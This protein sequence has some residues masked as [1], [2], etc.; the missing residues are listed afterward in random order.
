MAFPPPTSLE[1]K[2]L[3]VFYTKNDSAQLTLARSRILIPVYPFVS[4]ADDS[5]V[6]SGSSSG[7]NPQARY[8][9]VA[10]R[11][12]ID[13]LLLSCPDLLHD[14]HRDYTVYH[15]DPLESISEDPS[16]QSLAK[17]GISVGLGLIS[18]LKKDEKTVAITGTVM[19][20]KTGGEG[21]EVVFQLRE[22]AQVP[23]QGPSN[24]VDYTDPNIAAAIDRYRAEQEAKLNSRRRRP[25]APQGPFNKRL[26]PITAH[27]EAERLLA[28]AGAGNYG[29]RTK[30]ETPATHAPSPDAYLTPAT[31]TASTPSSSQQPP[32]SQSTVASPPAS[33]TAGSNASQPDS[34]TI[35]AILSLI[36]S[37]P[38]AASKV[39]NNPLL[40]L[41]LQSLLQQHS[42]NTPPAAQTSSVVDTSQDDEVIV[43]DKENV[44][45]SAFR[46]RA[47]LEGAKLAEMSCPVPST[48][49]STG[50]ETT[51]NASHGLGLGAR[52][53]SVSSDVSQVRSQQNTAEEQSSSRNRSS[54]GSSRKGKEKAHQPNSNHSPRGY[55]LP[56][57][58]KPGG[59]TEPW[60]SPPRS[61]HSTFNENTQAGSSRAAPI[62]IPDSPL[63][64]TVPA[65][66]PIRGKNHASRKPYVL[67]EW[68]RTTT[69]TQPRFSE[70]ALKAMADAEKQREEDRKAKRA[71]WA[72]RSKSTSALSSGPSSSSGSQVDAS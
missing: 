10:L 70:E 52:S 50:T 6:A 60:S 61:R 17:N 55:R 27:C 21:V 40:Q 2:L 13:T 22:R 24:G 39:E 68:A 67:P 51:H 37:S 41:A 25:K 12:C 46:R 72:S 69:A 43:L 35:L 5:A 42:N 8:A 57:Y 4:F 49:T 30:S 59:S 28:E 63:A 32:S 71:K 47:E 65:S 20:M 36:D 16:A 18:E 19:K 66:S 7:S 29:R 31:S 1:N 11:A 15:F 26:Q 53:N 9:T 34:A 56:I 58:A 62:V 44:N 33:Q 3:R 64:P 38:D 54:S 14:R 45:P 23:R 48:S